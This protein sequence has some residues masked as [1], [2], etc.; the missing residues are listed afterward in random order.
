LASSHSRAKLPAQPVEF[1]DQGKIV[2]GIAGVSAQLASDG[3]SD[4]CQRFLVFQA[5]RLR[6]APRQPTEFRC[7]RHLERCLQYH[8][9]LQETQCAGAFIERI[10]ALLFE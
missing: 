7:A 8:S 5:K 9:R 2:G 10:N 6:N 1:G 3:D 4:Q